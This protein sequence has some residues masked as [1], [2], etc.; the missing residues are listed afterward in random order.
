MGRVLTGEAL[1][2]ILLQ[3]VPPLLSWP[4]WFAH[5]EN[6]QFHA[7]YI[8]GWLSFR[9]LCRQGGRKHH[10]VLL[11]TNLMPTKYH[12]IGWN[13]TEGSTTKPVFDFYPVARLYLGIASSQCI[14]TPQSCAWLR[15]DIQ[16]ILSM[17]MPTWA[18]PLS[19]CPT[20]H[21]K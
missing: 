19:G 16:P 13:S 9:Q 2:T 6:Y 14:A 8:P 4:S 12:C 3:P 17:Q 15:F 7:L 1:P 20:L 18:L 11:K 5:N 10:N 21:V